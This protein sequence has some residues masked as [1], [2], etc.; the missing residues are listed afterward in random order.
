M[1]ESL[2]DF[3][4]IWFYIF[5]SYI[6]LENCSTNGGRHKIIINRK[7]ILLHFLNC[8]HGKMDLLACHSPIAKLRVDG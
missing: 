4:L 1:F 7:T 2:G 6:I 3:C 5:I 8:I